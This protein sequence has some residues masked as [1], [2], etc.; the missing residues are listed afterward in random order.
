MRATLGRRS[1][2]PLAY[3]WARMIELLAALER[4]VSLLEDDEI[5]S[6]DTRVRVER[7]AGVGA[8]AVE[9]PRGTLFHYYE[10]D[11][12]GRVTKAE[13]VVAT[14][15]NNGAINEAVRAASGGSVIDGRITD[16]AL[17]KMELGIRAYD[18]CL[19]CATHEIGRMPLVV[20]LVAADGTVL[21][22]KGL[23]DR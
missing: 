2:H 14:T 15:Q 18:P 5:V 20:E 12:V 23:S 1:Q 13:L 4:M 19:S 16:G 7:R 22:R 10:A 11:D 21:D 9:A 17:R 6:K 8:A 3:H